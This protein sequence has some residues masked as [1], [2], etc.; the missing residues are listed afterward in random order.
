MKIQK[1]VEPDQ[2]LWGAKEMA[3]LKV[4]KLS[5]KQNSNP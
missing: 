2:F 1:S 5:W 4:N 3:A